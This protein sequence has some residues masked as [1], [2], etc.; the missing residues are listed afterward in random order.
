MKQVFWK[1][2]LGQFHTPAG[3]DGPPRSTPGSGPQVSRVVTLEGLR[4]NL[5]GMDWSDF[6]FFSRWCGNA[7]PW[8]AR[9]IGVVEMHLGFNWVGS[10]ASKMSWWENL[11]MENSLEGDSL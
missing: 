4:V 7:I 1:G 6:I 10:T 2:P 3:M 5:E 11:L 9:E 8:L